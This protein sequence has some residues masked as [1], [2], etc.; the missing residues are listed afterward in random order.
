MLFIYKNI[1]ELYIEYINL[2]HDLRIFDEVFVPRIA[3]RLLG[4]IGR[5]SMSCRGMY[6]L[7]DQLNPFEIC[8]EM[9]NNVYSVG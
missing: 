8:L 2:K 1:F 7:M 6:Q 4:L 9:S 5:R 3:I